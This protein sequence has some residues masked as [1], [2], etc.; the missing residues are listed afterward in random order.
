MVQIYPF[1]CVEISY[2]SA[3]DWSLAW[4]ILRCNP[5]FF[6]APRYDNMLLNIEGEDLCPAWLVMAFQAKL[7]GLGHFLDLALIQRYRRTKNWKPR[8][9]W[10]GCQVFSEDKNVSFIS[11]QYAIWGCVM[12]PAFGS[13]TRK[14]SMYYIFDCLNSDMFLRVNDIG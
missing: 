10:H 1:H 4:D 13:S 6:H 5:D 14:G 8:T 12:V 7:A 9:I 2:Q 3:D 11:L